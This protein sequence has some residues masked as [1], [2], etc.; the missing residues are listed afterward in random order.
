MATGPQ[1]ESTIIFVEPQDT[2][3]SIHE[4]LRKAWGYDPSRLTLSHNGRHIHAFDTMDRH[5]FTNG[6][7]IHANF[8]VQGGAPSPTSGPSPKLN[9]ALLTPKST[10]DSLQGALHLLELDPA[11]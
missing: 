3:I 11:T 7:V 6:S 2:G 8:R 4:T 1:H 5:S 10:L 9:K